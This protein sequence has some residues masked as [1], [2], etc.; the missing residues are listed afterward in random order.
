[1]KEFN[2]ILLKVLNSFF[3]A[4]K[5][6]QSQHLLFSS[7]KRGLRMFSFFN[8]YSILVLKYSVLFPFTPSKDLRRLLCVVLVSQICAF[9]Y[10]RFN[11][12]FPW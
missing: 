12:S 5:E 1:M 8:I 7:F 3:L 10:L 2:T 4:H 11:I 9:A 6:T